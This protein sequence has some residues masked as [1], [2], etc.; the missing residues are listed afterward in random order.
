ML[1][2]IADNIGTIVISAL[3]LAVVIGIIANMAKKKAKGESMSCGCGCSGCPSASICHD[4]TGR[5][6]N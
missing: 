4:Q 1:Q 6:K 5:G 2:F 3:L